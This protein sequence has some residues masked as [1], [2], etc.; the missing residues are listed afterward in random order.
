MEFVRTNLYSSTFLSLLRTILPV[1]CL[2][3]A[4]SQVY[5]SALQTDMSMASQLLSPCITVL[6]EGLQGESQ[7]EVRISEPIAPELKHYTELASPL[8][9]CA[10]LDRELHIY[11]YEDRYMPVRLSVELF[12]SPPDT[13]WAPGTFFFSAERFRIVQ[14][15]FRAHVTEQT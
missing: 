7:D 3:I 5:T 11:D 8:I 6:L 13:W 12:T 10:D 15:T 1:L 4:D 2:A 14:H 9:P